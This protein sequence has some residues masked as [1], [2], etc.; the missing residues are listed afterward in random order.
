MKI[1]SKAFLFTVTLL[2]LSTASQAGYFELNS[3]GDQRESFEMTITD[4]AIKN[5]VTVKAISDSSEYY[6][7]KTVADTK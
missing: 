5:P 3:V 1:S 6:I 2:A 7:L 4:S